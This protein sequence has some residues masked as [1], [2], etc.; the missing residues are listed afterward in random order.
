MLPLLGA[1]V[2]SL[3]GELGSHI[4][5]SSAKK[6]N[7]Q[8]NFLYNTRSEPQCYY[9]HLV[10]QYWLINYNKYTALVQDVNSGETEV[11]E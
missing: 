1:R 10:Y 4:T 7:K 3:V 8:T 11:G 6:T 2:R 9:V 5:R